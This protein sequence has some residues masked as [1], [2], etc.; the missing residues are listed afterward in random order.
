MANRENSNGGA[1]ETIIGSS[2]KVEGDLVSDG[3]IRVE[4][5]VT[6]KIKTNKNLYVGPSAKIEADVEAANAELAGSIKGQVKVSQNLNL[7]ESGRIEGDISCGQLSISPG[8]Y[9]SGSCAMPESK[10][11]AGVGLSEEEEAN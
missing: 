10:E 5:M 1:S 8:A 3:D 6:G 2:V 11:A 4:G 7:T 9:F